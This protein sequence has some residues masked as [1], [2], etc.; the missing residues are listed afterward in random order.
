MNKRPFAQEQPLADSQRLYDLFTGD[1]SEYG[2]F[3]DELFRYRVETVFSKVP[4]YQ[5]S[6][7]TKGLKFHDFRTIDGLS[8][9]P[10][11]DRNFIQNQKI[12]RF[13]NASIAPEELPPPAFT[14]G[15]SGAPL[16]LY[17]DRNFYIASYR[18]MQLAFGGS[19]P[20]VV[21]ALSEDDCTLPLLDDCRVHFISR[22]SSID[23]LFA[24]L[25]ELKAQI[26]MMRPD[27]WRLLCDEY[28]YDLSRLGLTVAGVSGTASTRS[29]RSYFANYLDCPVANMYGAT[30]LGG[31]IFECPAGREHVLSYQNY[32]EILDDN[33]NEVQRGET[34]NFVWTNLDNTIMPFIRYKI[35]DKGAFAE[36][37]D[38]TCGWN[39]PIIENLNS[40]VKSHVLLPSGLK[41]SYYHFSVEINK[42]DGAALFRQYQLI[43]EK[44][45]FVRFKVVKSGSF[46][47]SVM[48]TII[49]RLRKLLQNE[50]WLEV[51][52]V[53]RIEQ[54]GNKF[55]YF[56]PLNEAQK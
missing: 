2:K 23:R 24:K 53:E 29:E 45:D 18:I 30:E 33:G 39:G 46:N 44:I 26:V 8:H 49:A 4:F 40:M 35:G 19:L 9:F 22:A 41:I 36:N 21:A 52:Y 51:S 55:Q 12:D 6:M 34:G 11:S 17:T 56:I 7:K 28:G 32:L 38:C 13:I 14:S 16:K 15:T 1:A 5:E 48:Q 10:V 27:R 43:Q 20:F 42:D 37:Q 31:A 3:I 54:P 50:I 47:E 25:V